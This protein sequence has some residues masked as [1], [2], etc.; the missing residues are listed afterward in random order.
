MANRFINYRKLKELREASKNGNEKAKA[1]IDK[2]MDANPD[3]DSIDR[4][5]DDYYSEAPIETLGEI[6]PNRQVEAPVEPE[7][8]PEAV[9]EEAEAQAEAVGSEIGEVDPIS[10]QGMP[11]AVEVDI[12]E[13]LDRELDGILDVEDVKDY[14][15]RDYLGDKRKNGL[16]AKKDAAYFK[17]FDQGGRE[18]YLNRKKD[19]YA[20]S[21]DGRLRD[22]ERAHGDLE[23]AIGGYGQMLTD[24]PDDDA[25]IDVSVA[26]KAYD[27]LTGDDVS[28][29]AFGRSWDERDQETIK[30][31][32]SALVAK[33]GKKN[34]VAALN[35]L[36][37]DNNA[38]HDETRGR[39]ES[40]ISRY[41]K[42]LESL[43][44]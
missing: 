20:H 6:E 34:V 4:L 32:L 30:A 28:M 12:S 36:R 14:S 26:T 25:E 42:S 21:F 40:S 16:K 38:W 15:F 39:I 44:K 2:Y 5:L 3:M 18:S 1:I 29:G 19:E 10:E 9:E 24:M 7:P 27:D 17:A 31:S 13:E 35:T 37:E 11:E 33:Y 8:Q 22:A 23:N 43:L 41:G